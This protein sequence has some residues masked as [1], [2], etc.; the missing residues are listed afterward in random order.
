MCPGGEWGAV[1]RAGPEE[2]C[3][4]GGRRTGFERTTIYHCEQRPLLHAHLQL[5]ILEV[6]DEHVAGS[7]RDRER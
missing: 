3:P 1:R 2:G 5:A 4:K 6:A 7:M